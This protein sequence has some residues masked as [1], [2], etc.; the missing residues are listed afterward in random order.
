LKAAAEKLK[1]LKRGNH[2]RKRKK[3]MP[4]PGQTW[5]CEEC[6]QPVSLETAG[7]LTL[8]PEGVRVAV[9]WDC[10]LKHGPFTPG[11]SNNS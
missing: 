5:Q 1:H 9:C 3:N 8:T 2:S 10:L 11:V 4:K 6:R 7:S